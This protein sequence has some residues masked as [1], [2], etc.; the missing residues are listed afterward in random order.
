MEIV[1][2]L[3]EKYKSN[4]YMHDKL[5][6]YLNNLPTLMQSVEQHHIQKTQQLLELSEKKDKY[7]QNFLSTHSI[8]YIPQTELFIEYKDQN[9]SIVSDDDIAHYVL[10][11]LYDNDLKIWK[12][13]IKKH[14]IKRIKENLFTTT[15]PESATIKSVFQSLT[16]FTSK[17][18][19]KYFLTILGDSLLGK[20]ESFIYFIDSSYKKV[21][22]K[23]VEQIYAMTNK[24][25]ADIF[26]YKF[27]DHKYEQCRMITGKCPELYQFPTKIL[28]VISVATYLST[29]YTN[30]EGFLT[31]CNDDDFIEKTLYLNKHTPENIITMFVDETMHKTGTT[32]YKDFYF[33]WRSYLKQKE[34]PLVISDANFKTILTNLQL[35][36]D[37]VIPLTSKQVYIQNVKLF[38]D[39]NPYLEDQYDVCDLVDMYNETQPMEAKIN[40]EM[41][42]DIIILLQ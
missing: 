3:F 31:Q 29:K 18:H 6:Q 14:I 32:T 7:V 15:V 34:L 39:K 33:L 37:D 35:I 21:I 27:W 26:K 13:K 10:S 1:S 28:N 17:N 36:Q 2:N 20:K 42:R 16:M 38:L 19:I 12:Y 41:L 30:S 11:E 23:C 24:S 4:P 9:Y 40:E 5:S 8:F 25:V 22:R